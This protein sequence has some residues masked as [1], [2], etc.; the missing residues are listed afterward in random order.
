V[1]NLWIRVYTTFTQKGR[2]GLTSTPKDGK[3]ELRKTEQSVFKT[4]EEKR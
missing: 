4:K 1:D 2:V 3:I